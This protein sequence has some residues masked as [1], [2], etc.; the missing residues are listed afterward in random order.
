MEGLLFLASV[1]GN[2]SR[3][4]RYVA[5]ARRIGTRYNVKMPRS[6]KMSFCR[7]CSSY[8]ATRS[9]LRVRLNQ[10]H[11]TRTCAACGNISRIGYAHR[12]GQ[13]PPGDLPGG[14]ESGAIVA[15]ESG[16]FLDEEE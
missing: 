14:L 16:E 4:I 3:S 9:S 8:T 2:P 1:T 10:G 5:L 13:A 7:A 12:H 15:E 11:L 6:M